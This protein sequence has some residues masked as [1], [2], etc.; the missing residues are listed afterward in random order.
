MCSP[1][2][3]A[4]KQMLR[5]RFLSGQGLGKESE[6]LRHLKGLRPTL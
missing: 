5:Q 4:T 6:A 1:N 2:E 3:V